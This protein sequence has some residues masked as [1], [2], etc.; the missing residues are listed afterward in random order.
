M[1]LEIVLAGLQ[2][3]VGIALG[4]LVQRLIGLLEDLR[5][6]DVDPRMNYRLRHDRE[7]RWAMIHRATVRSGSIHL[8]G[9]G[10]LGVWLY[11]RQFESGL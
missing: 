10:P 2:F 8:K 5:V 6:T 7:V 11:A 9:D 3:G 4:S 1:R